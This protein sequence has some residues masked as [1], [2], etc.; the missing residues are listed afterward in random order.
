MYFFIN[1]IVIHDMEDSCS[2]VEAKTFP[3]FRLV[4]EHESRIFFETEIKDMSLRAMKF[5]PIIPHTCK[6][7]GIE[8]NILKFLI[9]LTSE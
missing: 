2:Y 6:K 9:A 5:F 7:S 3:E 4:F 1:I 8:G